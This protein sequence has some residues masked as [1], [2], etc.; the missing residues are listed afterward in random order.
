MSE[1]RN[2]DNGLNDHIGAYNFTTENFA[3]TDPVT[4]NADPAGFTSK[5]L[6]KGDPV[7]LGVALNFAV[8]Q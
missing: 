3:G 2:T 1:P 8:L 5:D 6:T 7:P 4:G